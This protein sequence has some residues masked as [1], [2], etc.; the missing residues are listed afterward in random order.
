M[1]T[2]KSIEARDIAHVVHG[3][4]NLLA[5]ESKGPMVIERGEGIYVFDNTGRRYTEAMA[6]LWCVALGFRPQGKI[7]RFLGLSLDYVK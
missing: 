4:T 7:R 2:Q 3:Y 1:A 5:H 6:G